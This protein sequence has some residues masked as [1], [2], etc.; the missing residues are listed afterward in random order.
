MSLKLEY[1]SKW[2]VTQNGISLKMECHS[3]FNITQNPMSLKFKCHSIWYVSQ[4]GMWLNLECHSNWNVTQIEMSLKLEC[5]SNLNVTQIGRLNRL[6]RVL[7][8][9]A[10]KSASIG[11]ISILF[12][13]MFWTLSERNLTYKSVFPITFSEHS[14]N[15]E[16]GFG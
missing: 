7:N 12:H 15:S 8:P 16:S 13:K 3:K 6:K 9:K 2:N 11:W 4:I 14:F 1:H 5:H 10:S